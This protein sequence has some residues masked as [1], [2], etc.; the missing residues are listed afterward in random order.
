MMCWRH[1]ILWYQVGHQ[2]YHRW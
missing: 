1:S 2:T